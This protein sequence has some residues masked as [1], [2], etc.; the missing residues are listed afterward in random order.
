MAVSGKVAKKHVW[1]QCVQWRGSYQ[2][3]HVF[4][5]TKTKKCM[6]QNPCACRKWKL[7]WDRQ[8][9]K[10]SMRLVLSKRTFYKLHH[11]NT[12][13]TQNV[14]TAS[15][16]HVAADGLY[17]LSPNTMRCCKNDNKN[18]TKH[19]SYDLATTICIKKWKLDRAGNVVG[20]KSSDNLIVYIEQNNTN[21]LLHAIFCILGTLSGI[22]MES[23]NLQW[24]QVTM[25]S[26]VSHNFCPIARKPKMQAFDWGA[27]KEL[28][29]VD[30]GK[31]LWGILHPNIQLT[32]PVQNLALC[33]LWDEPVTILKQI[34]EGWLEFTGSHLRPDELLL[35]WPR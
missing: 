10:K 16:A 6:L 4:F 21:Q 27:A 12:T 30:E 31:S 17:F 19:I 22:I 33:R 3:Y 11:T 8:Q 23:A 5:G 34:S 2:R 26:T 35:R 13:N 9:V 25:P 24:I 15:S 18:K 32:N 14:T 29:I 1:W 7:S 28:P 20:L